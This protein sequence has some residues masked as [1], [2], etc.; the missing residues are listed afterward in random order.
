MERLENQRAAEQGHPLPYPN[1][2][3]RV[4]AHGSRVD[5][6]PAP[7][8]V[9][10]AVFDWRGKEINVLTDTVG[11]PPPETEARVAREFQLPDGGPTILLGDPFDL[12]ANK[13]A[14]H[15][16]KDRPHIPILLR[17]IARRPGS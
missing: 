17:F 14:V 9:P 12:L 6:V 16:Q 8:C 3:D 4:S 11:L 15:R 5:K 13:L 10:A 2:W 7:R 1:P